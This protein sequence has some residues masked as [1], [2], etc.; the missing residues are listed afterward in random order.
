LKFIYN[1]DYLGKIVQLFY[2]DHER[3]IPTYFSMLIIF[4]AAVILSFIS[5]LERKRRSQYVSRWIT[6]TI[7]FLFMAADEGFQLHER[8]S[9]PFKNFFAQGEQGIFYFA[10]VIPGIAIVILIGLFFISFLLY[11]S[12]PVRYRFIVAAILYLGGAIGFELISGKYAELYGMDNWIYSMILI[13]IEE[14]LEIAGIIF[15]IW[16]LLKYCEDNFKEVMIHF[17][18]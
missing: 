15:F 18:A 4:L 7:G 13:T 5:M 12:R 2:L 14:S 11:L 9:N 16:A 10:W 17:K 3:N 8:L 6:L 1:D